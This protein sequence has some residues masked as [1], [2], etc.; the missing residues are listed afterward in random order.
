VRKDRILKYSAVIGVII[1]L[2]AC[3]NADNEPGRMNIDEPQAEAV[4]GGKNGIDGDISDTKELRIKQIKVMEEYVE[5]LEEAENAQEVAEAIRMY[6]DSLKKI[7]PTLKKMTEETTGSSSG[8]ES[9]D[10]IKWFAN[11]MEKL[12]NR[13]IAAS[14]KTEKY[15]SNPDVR[16]AQQEMQKV[17]ETLQ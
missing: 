5:A 10:E 3:G 7:V 8:I 12:A 15:E 1:G 14:L 16:K 9:S 11:K 4:S 13:L 2:F 17:Q 6:T